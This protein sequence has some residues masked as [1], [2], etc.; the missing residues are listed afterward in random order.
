MDAAMAAAIAIID[1]CLEQQPTET[2]RE[3]VEQTEMEKTS[4]C[5]ACIGVVQPADRSTPGSP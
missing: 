5:L 1:D 4:F 2:F 3:R